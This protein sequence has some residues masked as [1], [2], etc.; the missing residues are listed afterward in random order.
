[1]PT[2]CVGPE[3]NVVGG[4]LDITAVMAMNLVHD[5]VHTAVNNGTFS[6][7]R[8]LPGVNHHDWSINWT[9]TYTVPVLVIPEVMCLGSFIIAPQ[10]N[11]TFIRARALTAVG[12]AA[13]APDITGEFDSEFGG[14]FDITDQNK[15]ANPE[16]GRLHRGTG[17]WTIRKTPV[18]LEP[19]QTIYLAFRMASYTPAPWLANANNNSPGHEATV[20]DTYSRLWVT[21][22]GSA[23]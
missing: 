3:F 19:G 13:D 14:G 15:D 22:L 4:V 21:A 10:P 5:Q 9:N 12:G 7:Q 11:L 8:D 18:E 20:R 2:V 6:T 23:T 1:M 17:A 16:S